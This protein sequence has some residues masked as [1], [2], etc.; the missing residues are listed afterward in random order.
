MGLSFWA[1]TIWLQHPIHKR[2]PAHPPNFSPWLFEDHQGQ[3]RNGRPWLMTGSRVIP[4]SMA[5]WWGD[6]SCSLCMKLRQQPSSRTR[7]PR[8]AEFWRSQAL[9]VQMSPSRHFFAHH[10]H[11]LQNIE[12]LTQ[13]LDTRSL[14]VSGRKW[15]RN[16][17]P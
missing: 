2:P 9:K 8:P 16:S 10:L 6:R 12:S 7:C 11:I 5:S 3:H 4:A 17:K 1:Q 15:L 13:G 14:P